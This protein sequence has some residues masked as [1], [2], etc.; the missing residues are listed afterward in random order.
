M[1]YNHA[2]VSDLLT[3]YCCEFFPVELSKVSNDE[4]ILLLKT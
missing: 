1:V 3:F 4:E 2:A